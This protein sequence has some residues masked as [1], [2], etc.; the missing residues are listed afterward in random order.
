MFTHMITPVTEQLRAELCDVEDF[1][2]QTDKSTAN[3]REHYAPVVESL[4]ALTMS[5]LGATTSVP[6]TQRFTDSRACFDLGS[7]TE[8]YGAVT[9]AVTY[10][11][12]TASEV[13]AAGGLSSYENTATLAALSHLRKLFGLLQYGI[14]KQAQDHLAAVNQLGGIMPL[15][16]AAD[17]LAASAVNHRTTASVPQ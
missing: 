13:L 8:L 3:D 1:L 15:M 14:L 6:L 4:E 7:K 5:V 16:A 9:E 12:D 17:K 2:S 11:K 10:L